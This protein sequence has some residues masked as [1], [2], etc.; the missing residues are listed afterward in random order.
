MRVVAYLL[1]PPRNVVEA[2]SF[3]DVVNDHC[4]NAA[5]IVGAS[6]GLKRLL[7]SGI[8]NLDLEHIA[9]DFDVLRRELDSQGGFMLW[10]V[11]V[12][13]EAQGKAALPNIYR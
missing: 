4:S 13:R 2:V 9:I 8:P 11:L 3:T 1:Y 10:I 5:P 12:L 7:P 6:D